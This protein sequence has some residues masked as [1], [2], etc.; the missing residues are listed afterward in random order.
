MSSSNSSQA[1]S[2]ALQAIRAEQARRAAERR[3][4]AAMLA[5]AAETRERCKSLKQFIREAWH[6]LE[7]DTPYV[8]GW[9]I[10][11]VA[12]HLEAVH[13]GELTRLAI[14]EPPGCMKSL[15]ASV[16]FGAWEWGP[17]GAPWLRY[18]TTSYREDYALRDARKMKQI[19]ESDWYQAHWPVKLTRGGEGDY[20]NDRKGSRYAVPFASLTAGRGDRLIIDDP[21]STE[22]VESDADRT[23][24]VRI[25]RESVPSRVNDPMRSAIIV[26]MHRLHPDDVCGVID[27]MGLGYT[28]VTLP[29]EFEPGRRMITKWARDPRTYEGELLFPERFTREALDRDKVALTSHAY[30][31]QYQQRPTSREGGMF[32]RHW[33][34]VVEAVPAGGKSVRKWDLAGSVPQRGRGDPDWT[35]GVKMTRVGDLF[36]VEDVVRLRDTAAGVRLAI[37]NTAERDGK[38]VLIHLSQDPGQAGKE[39]AAS[40]VAMLAGW[41]V[42]AKRETGAKDVRA[43]PFAAQVEAGNVKLVRAAW[44]EAFVDELADFP[45]G[46]DDQLD[47]ASGAFNEL[48]GEPS[49][50]D[51]SGV[52][53]DLD[54]FKRDNPAVPPSR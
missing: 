21:H 34:G 28:R 45:V 27:K 25:F 4:K 37:K 20:E 8:H 9:H 54:T 49:G 33:F 43:E 23:R 12:E 10:D 22:G 41:R 38:G 50:D 11:C 31:G 44:N 46:H 19:V 42:K 51:L 52:V 36:Y 15:E 24:A 3:D 13:R 48:A 39:Q 26:I 29:M 17:G 40:L 2:Q 18:F 7:P 32:K 5:R 1:A 53:I 14:N 6:V 35:A 30:N 16:M 47:G